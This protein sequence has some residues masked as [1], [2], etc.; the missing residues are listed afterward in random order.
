[1]RKPN[2]NIL[3][4]ALLAIAAFALSACTNTGSGSTG[5][6]DNTTAATVNGK[7]I[8]LE[9]VE[10]IIKQQG[11]GQ[12]SKLSQLELTAAR[13]QVL[14]NLIQ[15]EVLFQKAE[16]EGVVPSNEDITAEYNKTKQES[17][18]SAEKF[19]EE[20][21]KAG[22]TEESARDSIK[23]GLAV[24]RLIDKVTGKI[25]PPKDSDIEAFFNSNP[26]S[27]KNKRGAQ[28]AA[29]VIDPADNGEGDTTKNEVEAQQKAKEVGQ[30]ALQNGDFASLAR[31]N[32]EDPN[33]KMSGGDWRFFTE[34]EMKQTF[35][36][37]VAEYVMNKMQ[38]GQVIPQAIP[39]QGKILIIKLQ[40]RLEKDE[41][42]TL[43]SPK[44]RPQIIDYLMG[45]RKDLL[46]QSYAAMAMN[47]AKI[48]NYLAKKVVDNPNDL[49]GA[50][51]ASTDT[52]VTNTNTASNANT[53]SNGNSK[54]NV[55][56]PANAPVTS[57][58]K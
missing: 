4:V 51:P 20:M 40:S 18:L 49:S 32:S 54:M 9:E 57:N 27:F 46:K 31:E 24:Q 12:E 42:Q 36:A 53:M 16:K 30:K 29:I 17:G 43:E 7:A 34:D 26:A 6:V 55:N 28:L 19:D 50:R 21:K 45:Q 25:E 15:N 48:E 2:F 10:R 35:G 22:Q 52:P 56:A 3:T 39:L 38:I 47:E 1:M 5:S 41:D 44:V 37:G 8:K 33:T 14:E 58:K 13:M 11:Q 23:K